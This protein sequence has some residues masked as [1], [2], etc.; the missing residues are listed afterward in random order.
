LRK[1]V[2]SAPSYQIPAGI[3]ENLELLA[4]RLAAIQLLFFES[5]KAQTLPHPVDRGFLAEMAA[6]HNLLYTVHL[7]VDRSISSRSALECQEAVEEIEYL[8][9]FFDSLPVH[10]FDLHVQGAA[11]DPCWEER[12]A[13]SLAFLSERL[14]TKRELIALENT[15]ADPAQVRRL[16][17]RYGF[18]LCLDMGHVLYY[19]HDWQK[20]LECAPHARHLHLHGVGDGRDHRPLSSEDESWCVRLVDALSQEMVV[21]TVENYRWRDCAESL[22]RLEQWGVKVEGCGI[23]EV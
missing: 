4:P 7:P 8:V 9:D 22:R 17:E 16:A 3:E 1:L 6:R 21:A 12:A 13:A 18:S 5:R 19:G 11:S 23:M 20:A 10:A 2:L 14:G 15:L